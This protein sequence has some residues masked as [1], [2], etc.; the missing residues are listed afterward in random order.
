MEVIE[1]KPKYTKEQISLREEQEQLVKKLLP[2][3][4]EDIMKLNDFIDEFEHKV[5][6]ESVGFSFETIACLNNLRQSA[7]EKLEFVEN[8]NVDNQSHVNLV[9]TLSNKYHID[10]IIR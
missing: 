3:M 1:V 5:C 2:L 10:N 8:G 7:D 4:R 9:N 6:N